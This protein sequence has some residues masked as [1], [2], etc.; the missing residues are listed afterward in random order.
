[1][2]QKKGPPWR[3]VHSFD[4]GFALQKQ[5]PARGGFFKFWCP[6]PDKNA[7]SIFAS[8]GFARPGGRATGCGE[9]IEPSITGSLHKSK[10]PARGGFFKFWC[11]NPDKNAGSIFA[12]RGFARPGGR[13]TGCGECI[14]PSITGSLHKSKNPPEAGSLNFGARTRNRT[15]DTG[16]FN[17]LLYRLSYSG[18]GAH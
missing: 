8:R 17:P 10:K 18:N 1:M 4:N 6:N 14:E 9:C 7:R 11:P 2:T 12:S 15:R 16:I 13:A 3:S 5:K